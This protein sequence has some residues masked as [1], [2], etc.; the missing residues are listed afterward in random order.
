MQQGQEY[1]ALGALT[2][3]DE[4]LSTPPGS[5]EIELKIKQ[6]CGSTTENNSSLFLYNKL[7]SKI[8][9]YFHIIAHDR[10]I[11]EN[12]VNDRQRLYC[13]FRLLR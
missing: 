8:E 6:V 12:N 9:V 4:P 10:R 5:T 11:T 2:S 3:D 13:A 7:S 1:A